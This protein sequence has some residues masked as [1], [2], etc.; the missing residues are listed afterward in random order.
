MMF[1]KNPG[2]EV[3]TI[4]EIMATVTPDGPRALAGFAFEPEGGP[5][6]P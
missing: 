2:F 3:M 4:I 1:E 6:A 5:N